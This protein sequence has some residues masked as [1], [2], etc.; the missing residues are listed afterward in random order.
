MRAALRYTVVDEDTGQVYLDEPLIDLEANH[1]RAL[2]MLRRLTTDG[3]PWIVRLTTE[4][5]NINL[6]GAAEIRAIAE[7][8]P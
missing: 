8:E 2:R 4:D 5:E 6:F 3:V 1:E 7:W